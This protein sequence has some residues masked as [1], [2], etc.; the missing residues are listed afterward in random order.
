[1]ST[2]QFF[3]GRTIAD[4]FSVY[5]NQIKEVIEDLEY[6]FKSQ[7]FE[8]SSMQSESNIENSNYIITVQFDVKKEKSVTPFMCQ[9]DYLLRLD[10]LTPNQSSS[11][12]KVETFINIK[13]DQEHKSISYNKFVDTKE[14]IKEIEILIN[15]L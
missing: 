2:E 9:I 1:M 4:T 15:K 11:K 7:H 13:N 14:L 6:H 8:V 12:M 5:E 10:K 3:E